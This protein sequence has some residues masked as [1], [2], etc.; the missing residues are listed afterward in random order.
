MKNVFLRTAAS[1]RII[2]STAVALLVFLACE[3]VPLPVGFEEGDERIIRH[4]HSGMQ[5]PRQV[6]GF[7]RISPAAYDEDG[8]D[9]S[10]GYAISR[11]VPCT[12]TV[13]I[14]PASTGLEEHADEV[15]S[16]IESTYVGVVVLSESE[17]SHEHFGVAYPGELA[18]YNYQFKRRMD[19]AGGA[20]YESTVVV[21]SRLYL[22]KYEDWFVKYRVTYPEESWDKIDVQVG[23][24]REQ[25]VWP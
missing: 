10:V 9:V 7:H 19:M 4:A 15:K 23:A 8:R 17:K 5:F 20:I 3:T 21:E 14:Y 16:T 24:F 11:P 12:I 6:G 18:V 25:L 22:F 13:Y 2:F 1:L